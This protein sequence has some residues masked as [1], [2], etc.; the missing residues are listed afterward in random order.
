M[1]NFLIGITF[2]LLL[3]LCF[4]LLRTRIGLWVAFGFSL[5]ISTIVLCF[6]C[7]QKEVKIQGNNTDFNRDWNFLYNLFINRN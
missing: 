4:I 7:Q 6:L 3:L 2:S 5:L 1:K